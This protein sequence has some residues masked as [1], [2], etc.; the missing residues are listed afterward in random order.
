MNTSSQMVSIEQARSARLFSE[1]CKQL[2]YWG[3]TLVVALIMVE[4]GFLYLRYAPA[5]FDELGN[6]PFPGAYLVLGVIELLGSAVLLAPGFPPLKLW[7]YGAFALIFGD[8]VVSALAWSEKRFALAS[9][10]ALLLLAISFW[11]RP[12]ARRR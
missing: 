2:G 7:V 11:L 9:L 6:L 1:K 3:A 4:S 12:A 5:I 10:I 8:D